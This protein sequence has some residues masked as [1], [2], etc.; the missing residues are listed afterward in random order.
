MSIHDIGSGSILM[1]L[2]S[3]PVKRLLIVPNTSLMDNHQVELAEA[4]EARNH[5]LVSTV[6]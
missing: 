1:V 2:R 3:K 6:E 5:L 4:L